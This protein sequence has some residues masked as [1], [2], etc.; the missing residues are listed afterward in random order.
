MRRLIVAVERDARTWDS[1]ADR[2]VR[3]EEEREGARGEPELQ[4]QE[5]W[6]AQ[7]GEVVC[8]GGAFRRGNQVRVEMMFHDTGAS[9]RAPR[10][11]SYDSDA[12]SLT[13]FM[14]YIDSSCSRWLVFQKPSPTRARKS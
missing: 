14:A 11:Y 4:E 8:S 10:E 7:A 9:V 6:P 13:T 1:W 5:E 2:A 3:K 12:E